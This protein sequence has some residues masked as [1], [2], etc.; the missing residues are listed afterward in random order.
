MEDRLEAALVRAEAALDILA[1]LAARHGF[2]AR[3][4]AAALSELDGLLSFDGAQDG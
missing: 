2:L 1:D 4:V 3:E